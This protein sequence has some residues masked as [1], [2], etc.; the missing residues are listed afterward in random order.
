M[1]SCLSSIPWDLW[2]CHWQEKYEAQFQHSLSIH[3]NYTIYTFY[4][5]SFFASLPWLLKPDTNLFCHSHQSGEK[6][7][8]C[9]FMAFTVTLY[10]FSCFL[11]FCK[12]I[13]LTING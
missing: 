9:S 4:T 8:Q 12:T 3:E 5:S 11:T 7:A 6:L 2:I 10:L 13:T 1:R